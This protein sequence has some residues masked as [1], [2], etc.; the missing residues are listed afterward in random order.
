MC[1]DLAILLMFQFAGE[2]IRAVTGLPVPGPVIGMVLLLIALLAKLP[3]RQ[4]F[5]Q[6]PASS[7][8]ISAC[9]SC[10]PALA[11]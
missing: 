5:T 1:L 11:S 7:W 4:A 3:V 9:F 2:M 6:R 8:H 10:R